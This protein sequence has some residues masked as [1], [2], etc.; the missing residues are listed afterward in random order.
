MLE[1]QHLSSDVTSRWDRQVAVVMRT[2]RFAVVAGL[3]AIA[4]PVRGQHAPGELLEPD[5]ERRS[6]ST[7][8]AG[9]SWYSPRAGRWGRITDRRVYLLGFGR[10]REIGFAG[11]TTLVLTQEIPIAV[12][13]RVH[14]RQEYCY[15][16]EFICLP[17]R[18]RKLAV[19]VGVMPLG[20][21]WAIQTHERTRL[22]TSTSAGL[23]LFDSEMPVVRSRKRNFA[24]E[25]GVGLEN[26]LRGG[27][28]LTI[29]WKFHHLSNAGTGETN[30][31]LDAN[32]VYLSAG[33]PRA[34]RR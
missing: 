21:K 2:I 3:W 11:P 25:A 7:R 23:F 22:V 1:N 28:T 19:G 16:V 24:L 31:G 34:A 32:I 14:G 13:E 33:R 26:E 29:G 4:A 15:M 20:L 8:T 6:L 5:R 17:D 9:M 10:E 18:G 27:R 12:V 30:P